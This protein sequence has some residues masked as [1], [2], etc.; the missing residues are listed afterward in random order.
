MEENTLNT[1]RFKD[2]SWATPV[3]SK[4]IQLGGLGGIGSWTTLLLS[5]AGF[6]VKGFDYDTLEEHNLGGQLFKMPDNP[7]VLKTD[8]LKNIIDEF[9]P[10]H[11]FE[12]FPMRLEFDS[13][14][15]T[16]S[17]YVVAGFD[18]MKARKGLFEA[19]LKHL[20]KSEADIP[21]AI[22]ID[23]RMRAEGFQLY[24]VRNTPVEIEKYRA[25]LFNDED[26]PDVQCTIKA[27]SHIGASIGAFITA[28]L[29]N[30]FVT[31]PADPRSTPFRMFVDFELFYF[32]I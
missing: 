3:K 28:A 10:G 23:G 21:D 17:P 20:E 6:I 29:T 1:E 26:V 9:A 14:S 19:W 25:T 12:P 16:I 27:T 31:D 13:T 11:S 32:D 22:F 18:N 7:E 2:L 4:V 5:R 8:A 24:C 15:E 30:N